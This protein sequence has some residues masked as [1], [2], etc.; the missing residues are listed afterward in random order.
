L[1]DGK[2]VFDLAEVRAVVES[3]ATRSAG[4]T[5]GELT[6]RACVL[7]REGKGSIDVIIALR[8]SFDVVLEWQRKYVAESGSLLLPEP[9]ASRLKETFFVEGEPFTSEGLWNL[10]ERVT[11]RNVALTRRI[12]AADTEAVYDNGPRR[13]SDRDIPPSWERPVSARPCERY[14]L[15]PTCLATLG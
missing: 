2:H 14:A 7:F 12:R 5:T 1:A 9:L 6:A 13:P 10:L 15:G 11:S 8:Q 3:R 4:P